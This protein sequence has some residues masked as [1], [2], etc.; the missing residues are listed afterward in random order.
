MINKNYLNHNFIE[1]KRN[2]DYICS[3][4]K[5]MIWYYEGLKTQYWMLFNNTVSAGI[6][7]NLTCNEMIIKNIIE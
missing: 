3:K 4:C 1:M 2:N 6:L 7:L 5:I